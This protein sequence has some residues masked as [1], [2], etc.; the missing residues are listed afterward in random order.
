MPVN[1]PP[2]I[3]NKIKYNENSVMNNFDEGNGDTSTELNFNK[4]SLP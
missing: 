1:L 2:V 3:Q 4:I